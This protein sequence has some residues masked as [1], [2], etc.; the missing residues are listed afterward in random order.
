MSTSTQKKMYLSG[1]GDEQSSYPLDRYFFSSIP[2]RG[3]LLYL[4]IALRGHRLFRE[5]GEWFKGVMKLHNRHEDVS[6][7][8]WNSLA[9]R[10]FQN[11]KQFSAIYVGGGN[12]WSL[13]KEITESGF[14]E[15]LREYI[16]DGGLYYGG[17]AGAVICGLKIDIQQDENL[18][19]WPDTGGM[20]LLNGLSVVCHATEEQFGELKSMAE[21]NKTRLLVLAETAGAIVE[22]ASYKC[23]GSGVCRKI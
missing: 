1:G 20:D 13:I 8:V 12:T 16:E 11:L 18:V 17:S 22:G 9:D 23:V 10:S 21:K 3:A 14:K 15:V 7:E 6:L 5:A 19:N 4:P 2:K